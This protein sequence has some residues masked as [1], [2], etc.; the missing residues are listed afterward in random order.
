MKEYTV[1]KGHKGDQFFVL[2]GNPQ[3]KGGGNHKPY[4]LRWVEYSQAKA[5]AWIKAK[6]EE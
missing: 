3:K 5:E 4:Y 6:K 1:K 2:E